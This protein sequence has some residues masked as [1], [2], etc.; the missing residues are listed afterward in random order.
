MGEA[1]QDARP[2]LAAPVPPPAWPLLASAVILD[3]DQPQQCGVV[4][5]HTVGW[6][7]QIFKVVSML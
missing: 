4:G 5:E 7:L 6:E 2:K 3:G 1:H